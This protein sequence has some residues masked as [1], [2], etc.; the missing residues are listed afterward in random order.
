MVGGLVLL[1]IATPI[2][3]GTVHPWAF[4]SAEVLIFV[5]LA[6]ALLRMRETHPAPIGA[7]AVLRIAAPAA[8][9]AL[10]IGFQL[11][12]LPPRAVRVLSPETYVIYQHTLS[13][14]PAK[15]DYPQPTDLN[16][17]SADG[18]RSASETIPGQSLKRR[19]SGALTDNPPPS[20]GWTLAGMRT[21][22]ARW[23]YGGRWRPLAIAP[24][25][26]I[27]RALL[28]V[29]GF[30]LFFLVALYPIHVESPP[31][32]EDPLTRVLIGAI[33]VAGILV[34][35]LGL[36]EQATWNGKI[37]WFFVPLDWGRP[38]PTIGRELG[39]FVNPDHFAAYLAMVSPLLAARSICGFGGQ[40]R[41]KRLE[42][43]AILCSAAL[44][45]VACAI[46]LSESRAIWGGLVIAFALFGAM[47]SRIRTP[48]AFRT[49][50]AGSSRRR[51][52]LGLAAIA[53]AVAAI[54]M[55]GGSGREK[56]NARV[57]A[58]VSGNLG[59]YYRIGICRDTLRMIRDFPVLGVGAGS[60]PEAFVH[61]Q[62]GPWP[63]MYLR[64]A[65]NDYIQIAAELGLLGFAGLALVAWKFGNLLWK[66]WSRV[67]PRARITLAA[68]IAGMTVEAFHELFDFS[69][70]IPAIGYLFMIYAGLAVRIAVRAT[71]ASDEE[72]EA[73]GLM[74]MRR[75]SPF[76]VGAAA[77]FALAA[78]VQS[79]VSYDLFY[80]P[81][82]SFQQAR[83]RVLLHPANVGAQLQMA[84]WYWLEPRAFRE[85]NSA[86][87]LDP[88]NPYAHDLYAARLQESGHPVQ[89]REQITLSVTGDPE[90]AS[91]PYLN[92][93]VIPHLNVQDRMAIELGLWEA[94]DRGYQGAIRSLAGFYEVTKAPLEAAHVYVRGAREDRDPPH[95]RA[96][97]L[98]AA[99][100][101]YAQAGEYKEAR[102]ALDA[103]RALEPQNSA[104][105]VA[106]FGSVFSREKNV[107]A[108]EQL[109]NEGLDA[110]ID[111][112]LLFKAFASCA[113]AA[114][115]KGKAHA[116]LVK[117]AE[118]EPTYDNL[119]ELGRFNL[120]THNFDGAMTSF[121]RATE[122]SPSQPRAWLNLAIAEEGGYHYVAA[123]RDY[124]RARDLAPNDAQVREAY[125][126]FQK[127]MAA[128][129]SDGANFTAI[130]SSA[131]NDGGSL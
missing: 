43:V 61:Y 104:P 23:W 96:Q 21:A 30:A 62:K 35:T 124:L 34:A 78:I 25:L 24:N 88:N 69:L 22:L 123:G 85:L 55:V 94:V 101:D 64:E 116:A 100:E 95:E 108:A 86:V 110:G 39:P 42:V 111:P 57:A 12:P 2:C 65:H 122:I 68:L 63:S 44:V 17:M 60:W 79:G 89:A 37:L 4:R 40:N 1:I 20:R 52:L 14:W 72:K 18:L 87:W 26:G 103:A 90:F 16:V 28:M 13:G 50:P 84:S 112:V 27:T 5:V 119:M 58:S 15:V 91:H 118:Y 128:G 71:P 33:L 105:Y 51:L 77:V 67:D 92:P 76:M 10:L 127:K 75:A 82:K 109:L 97:F 56:I 19:S 98:I 29:S 114:G 49:G 45:I 107:V 8:A 83:M 9:V 36:V 6:F 117:L 130:P 7:A 125:A 59:L 46:L 81:S 106:L 66:R 41:R 113:E 121:R 131:P 53:I 126:A 80:P 129:R 73:R 31:N 3:F 102:R 70:T 47:L 74:L 99:G 11:L 32:G 120:G 48:E 38:H 115:A 54:V 93:Q